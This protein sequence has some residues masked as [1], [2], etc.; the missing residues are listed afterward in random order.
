MAAQSRDDCRSI[1]AT[2]PIGRFREMKMQVSLGCALK[3]KE[4]LGAKSS[5]TTLNISEEYRLLTTA[6]TAIILYRF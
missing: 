5:E 2:R 4:I 6:I 3:H 1:L